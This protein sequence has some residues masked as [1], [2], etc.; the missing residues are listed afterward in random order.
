[1]AAATKPSVTRATR[2]ANVPATTA[3]TSGKKAPKKVMTTNGRTSGTPRMT[4]ARPIAAASTRP[5]MAVPR[6]YAPS[7]C[8]ARPATSRTP[9]RRSRGK[10]PTKALEMRSPSFTKKNVRTRVSSRPATN[11]TKR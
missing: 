7:V 2:A 3:P 6:M 4:R 11:S 1:M 5:T 8:H 9:S 10:S